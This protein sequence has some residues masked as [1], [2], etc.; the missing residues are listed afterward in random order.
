M[1]INPDFW[2]GKRIF[3]TGHT[4]FKGS[5][6]AFWLT[7]LGAQVTGYALPPATKPNLFSILEIAKDVDSHQ[8]D[9]RD[10]HHLTSTMKSARPDIVIHMAAQALVRQSYVSPV[11][12]Y[13]TNVM[14]TVNLLES[15]RSVETVRVTI[16]I[17][18]D[19]CYENREWP[20]GYRESDAMGGH[21]PYS[22]SKGCAE[23]VT[24]AYRSSFFSSFCEPERRIALASARAG[25]VI[26]GGDWSPDRLI[27]D[28]FR[29]IESGNSVKIRNPLAVRP[30]QHVLEPLHGYLMLAE[31][32]WHEGHSFAEGWNFGPEES[33]CRPVGEIVAKLCSLW[34]ES[35]HW[36]ID[37]RTQPHEAQ[38]L[39]L[40]I[41]KS[42]QRLRWQPKWSLDEALRNTVSWQKAFGLGE[43]MR[44]I[45]TGQIDRYLTTEAT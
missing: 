12:T 3:L 14:G 18:S 6:L 10:L 1:G 30:W 23:L 11:E 42:R 36:E 15:I 21:D 37:H 19:K 38:M 33:G 44:R 34:G 2:V 32:L 26:G 29:A 27:P 7:R 4:G 45:T 41:A 25:N 43:D 16:N 39:R 35:A 13:A 40:D 9:V 17:T 22:S 31:N 5:W 20:W 24:A 8:G 28:V